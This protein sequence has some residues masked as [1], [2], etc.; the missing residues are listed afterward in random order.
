MRYAIYYSPD[1]GEQLEQLGSSWLGRSPF[2]MQDAPQPEVSGLAPLRQWELTSEPRRYGFH[3]TLK[4]P[5]ELAK[6]KSLDNLHNALTSFANT[7]K[8]FDLK[9]LH[10]SRLSHFLALTPIEPSEQLN[11]LASAC[12]REFD[13]LRAPLSEFDIARRRRANLDTKQDAYMLQWGYP[14][15]FEYFRFHLT[16]SGK[17]ENTLQTEQLF[18]AA[19]AHFKPITHRPFTIK[20]LGLACEEQRGS[21]FKM[22]ATYQLQ[23]HIA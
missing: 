21:P 1:Q 12:V 7:T 22:L 11:A 2:T 10:V 9:G 6:G 17:L 13:H 15:I 3:G 8:P 5:F 20:T 19:Q 4:P 14:Y 18:D 23:G 16:L